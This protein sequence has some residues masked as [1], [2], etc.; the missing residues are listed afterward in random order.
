MAKR[1]S[2]N[3]VGVFCLCA[4]LT[5]LSMSAANERLV[6]DVLE[7]PAMES[8]LAA[9][10]LLLDLARANDRLIAVGERGHIVYSDD[11]GESWTQGQV[12]VRTTLTAVHFPTPNKGWAVGHGGVILHSSDGGETWVKQLDGYEGSA[13]VINLLE[14]QVEAM[15]ARIDETEDEDERFDL[16]FELEDLQFTLED[17]QMDAEAGP[18]QPLLDVWFQDE[19][20]GLAVGSYGL[21]FRTED[22]G[23]SWQNHAAN[24][25]NPQR[26]NFNAITEIAGGD[27]FIAAESGLV[28]RSTDGG[29]SWDDIETPYNGSYFGVVGTSERNQV[30]AFGLRGNIYRSEDL[31]ESWSRVQTNINRTINSGHV[32]PNGDVVLVANDGAILLS[33]NNG[34]SFTTYTRPNRLSYIGVQVL[35]N[36]GLVLVGE[37]GA[38]R[39]DQSG[40][41]FLL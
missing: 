17:A 29:D 40:R 32:G 19:N 23:A 5:P 14:E 11:F 34:S 16:E 13:M 3:T 26:L 33:D 20:V 28:L 4:A 27:L 35:D 2:P 6:G 15:E 30:L 10:S 39:T 18:W 38:L 24:V 7:M 8:R 21:I 9:Q 22:G 25:P 31:G 41:D 36:K 1:F 12:P 37:Q